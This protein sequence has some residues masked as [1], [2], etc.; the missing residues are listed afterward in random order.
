M[1]YAP[2]RWC[3]HPGCGQYQPCSE[4]QRQREYDAERGSSSQRGYG[5]R[6][7][8]FRLSYLWQ[9]PLCVDCL[10]HPVAATEVHHIQKAAD[11]PDLMFDCDNLMALCKSCHSTRTANGE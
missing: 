6:W 4:H 5:R 2:K 11:R 1:P 10:P 7:Q 8:K 9:Y 3:T